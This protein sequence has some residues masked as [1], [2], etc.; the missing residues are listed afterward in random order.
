MPSSVPYSLFVYKWEMKLNRTRAMNRHKAK[1]NLTKDLVSKS[2]R[3]IGQYANVEGMRCLRRSIE[4]KLKLE[5]V[6][7]QSSTYLI[8]SNYKPSPNFKK[9]GSSQEEIINRLR[10]SIKEMKLND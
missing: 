10:E 2:L 5:N 3:N 9:R 4:Y 6:V 8:A 7:S 1:L